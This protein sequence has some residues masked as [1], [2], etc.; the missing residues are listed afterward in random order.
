MT[1]DLDIWHAFY[2]YRCWG[3]FLKHN[4]ALLDHSFVCKTFKSYYF[5]TV[6]FGCSSA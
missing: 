6:L 4:L 2:R 5:V 3:S 1:F